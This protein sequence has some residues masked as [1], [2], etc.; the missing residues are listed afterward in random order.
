MSSICM[1]AISNRGFNVM[2]YIPTLGKSASSYRSHLIFIFISFKKSSLWHTLTFHSSTAF[3]SAFQEQQQ[4]NTEKTERQANF[5][6]SSASVVA[7]R[8]QEMRCGKAPGNH[9]RFV[10]RL[11]PHSNSKRLKPAKKVNLMWFNEFF[12]ASFNISIHIASVFG[13]SVSTFHIQNLSNRFR[14]KHDSI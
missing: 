3:Q 8:K 12:L 6:L 1:F 10:S 9:H 5:Q 14:H 2:G 11:A 13:H 4:N 7:E